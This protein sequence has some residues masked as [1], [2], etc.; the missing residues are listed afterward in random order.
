VAS[1][2]SLIDQTRLETQIPILVDFDSRASE[3]LPLEG[4]IAVYR[5][6]RE[7]VHN[8]IKHANA[9]SIHVCLLQVGDAVRFEIADDGNGF[10]LAEKLQTGERYRS[11]RDMFIYIES[12]GGHL[13]IKT[14]PGSG[15]I[16]QGYFLISPVTPKKIQED[17]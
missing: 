4:Q 16:I 17:I 15:T 12:A 8:A 11:L 5:V 6:I 3:L 13:D 2:Q 1:L 10:M 14:A 7:A 9:H